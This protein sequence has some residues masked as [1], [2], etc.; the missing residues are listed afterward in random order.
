[1][2]FETIKKVVLA[3]IVL[4]FIFM[5]AEGLLLIHSSY[6]Q[7]V[8][9]KNDREIADLLA[10]AG[11]IASTQI[12][13][14]MDATQRFLESP[15]AQTQS[16]MQNSR[17][18]L[19]NGRRKFF[20]RL[21]LG[22][23][24]NPGLKN[25][26]SQLKMAYSR[27]IGLRA[28]V[29]AGR[30]GKASDVEYIYRRAALKQLGIGGSL[31]ARIHD[32]VLLRKSGDLLS[33]LLTYHGE[34]VVNALGTRY[35]AQSE[36]SATSH[37]Q[38]VQGDILRR[39]GMDRLQFRTSSTVI[40]DVLRFLRQPDQQAAEIFTHAILTGALKPTL[41][42]RDSWIMT[43]QTRLSFLRSKIMLLTDNL[44]TTGQT[45][46]ARSDR[47]MMAV[48]G[49][50]LA[51]L[52]L[53]AI[54][55]GLAAKGINLVD[56]L[57]RERETLVRELR[58]AA[59]TDLLPG[60]YNRRGFEFAAKALVT[61][62]SSRSRW[63]SIVLFDLDHFKRINDVH[64]HDAGDIVLRQV[65]DIAKQNFRGFDLLVRHGGEEFM[66]FLPDC[67]PEVAASVAE[68]VREA[69]EATSFNLPSGEELK[70][71]AS[72]GCAGRTHSAAS[73]NFEDL[74]KRADLALYAAK[75]A[76]RNRVSSGSV[77]SASPEAG[78]RSRPA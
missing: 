69:V 22:D 41:G 71:T 70:V 74:V 4:P 51:L 54:I 45:L 77:Q 48:V 23:Q 31:S 35:L 75:A 6:E 58:D 18:T 16:A 29:D 68:R 67:T 55:A 19:D 43:Q 13:D 76:G 47:H 61:Q 66:A 32:P 65:A 27:I 46:S 36:F 8:E 78:R 10:Q 21:P 20:T 56:R 39:S 7:F 30:Y 73:V 60:L 33:M 64:G 25:E 50:S 37:D 26:L 44:R 1:M 53:V 42:L 3:A 52:I 24:R 40:R 59:Q 12:I 28:A 11:A 34:M 38:L 15:D 14:E 9:L 57:T 72:F 5:M 62:A 49:L 2:N 63:F 17:T